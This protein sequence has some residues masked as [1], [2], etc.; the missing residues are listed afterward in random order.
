MHKTVYVNVIV[1]FLVLF[2]SS[3]FIQ[4]SGLHINARVSK[5]KLNNP[6]TFISCSSL[7]VL[8]FDFFGALMLTE[9][10]LH[11]NIAAL[12][13]SLSSTDVGKFTDSWLDA[14]ASYFGESISPSLT[15]QFFQ[16][17]IRSSLVRILDS[18]ELSSAV[19]EGST[20]F[21]FLVSA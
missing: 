17:V 11:R 8:T 15:H 19:P 16:W 7:N 21:D 20:T 6:S 10:S 2:V 18:Y 4:C 5:T 3:F 1:A 14:Y 12:L 13:P 9:S